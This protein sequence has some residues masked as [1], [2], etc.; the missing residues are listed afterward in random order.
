MKTIEGGLDHLLGDA[1]DSIIRMSAVDKTRHPVHLRKHAFT[2][3]RRATR[4]SPYDTLMDS[5]ARR[6]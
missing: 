6:E 3:P 2:F 5:T 4:I 1:A